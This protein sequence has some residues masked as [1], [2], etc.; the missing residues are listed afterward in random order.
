MMKTHILHPICM[1]LIIL[2]SACD[3]DDGQV[4]S[5]ITIE[6]EDPLILFDKKNHSL[7]LLVFSPERGPLLIKGGSGDYQVTNSSNEVVQVNYDGK[8]LTFLPQKTGTASVTIEDNTNNKYILSIRV[9]YRKLEHK[10]I[11]SMAIIEG[12]NMT[13]GDRKKLEEA[14]VSVKENASTAITEY[15]F[16]FTDKDQTTGNCILQSKGETTSNYN[17][18]H[19][20]YDKWNEVKKLP[21]ENDYYIPLS[22]VSHIQLCNK[23]RIVSNLYISNI[24]TPLHSKRA[25]NSPPRPSY[26]CII[27]DLTA[28]YNEEFPLLKHAYLIHIVTESSGLSI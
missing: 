2:L 20:G 25:V 22:N 13:E 3:K 19:S 6:N 9:G 5:P 15:T 24:F 18:Y 17:F 10:V 12:D 8:K 11:E 28:Q 1:L 27:T 26:R 7:D 21:L 16:I 23:D 4:F 14:I